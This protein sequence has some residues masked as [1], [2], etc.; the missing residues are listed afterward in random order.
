M[1]FV[2]AAK[3]GDA[4]AVTRLLP[5]VSS[6]DVLVRPIQG[7]RV[8]GRPATALHVAASAAAEEVVTLLIDARADVCKKMQWLRAL[9]PLHMAAT[10]S[11]ARLLLDA[12]A[13]PI[14]LD[15]R[16][17]E[18]AVRLPE[19]EL[20]PFASCHVAAKVLSSIPRSSSGTIAFI[21][22]LT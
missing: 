18:P 15:P 22:G 3:R 11:I 8:K 13:Q 1:H 2:Q 12:G 5:H 9:T 10:P 19:V 20:R 17:P 6:V 4:A 7:L 14:A 16:E 21:P